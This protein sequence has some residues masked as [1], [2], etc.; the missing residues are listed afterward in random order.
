MGGDQVRRKGLERRGAREQWRVR[1]KL[2]E[3]DRCV[4]GVGSWGREFSQPHQLQPLFEFNEWILASAAKEAEISD[5]PTTSTDPPTPPL[6]TF[7]SPP[8]PPLNFIGAHPDLGAG[9]QRESATGLG[10]SG[11]WAEMGTGRWGLVMR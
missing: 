8:A 9:E 1:E 3:E 2:K 6:P 10:A 4:E 11:G 7:P 5:P